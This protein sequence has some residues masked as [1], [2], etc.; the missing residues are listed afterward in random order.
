MKQVDENPPSERVESVA[1][2]VSADSSVDTPEKRDSKP[3]RSDHDE[4]EKKDESSSG[5]PTSTADDQCKPSPSLSNDDGEEA[6]DPEEG[7][8][9]STE[10]HEILDS[11][12]E[13]IDNYYRPEI[14]HSDEESSAGKDSSPPVEI[15]H[16]DDDDDDDGSPS[17]APLPER[18]PAV[19]DSV[20]EDDDATCG[21][22]VFQ[23]FGGCPGG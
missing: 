7:G 3:P 18:S 13:S 23:Y 19:N 22:V 20:D 1:E 9:E 8:G 2:E 16:S 5:R 12:D 6:V 15:L 14:L 11:E 4:E 21:L 10:R 17:P